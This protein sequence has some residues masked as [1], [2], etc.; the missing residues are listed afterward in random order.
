MKRLFTTLRELTFK[1]KLEHIWEYYKIQIIAFLFVVALGIS[2]Y[3]TVILNPPKQIY[4]YI[5]WRG[6]E[7]MP[8][9]MQLLGHHLSVIVDDLERQQVLV[10]NYLPS[11]IQQVDMQVASQLTAM[12]TMGEIDLLIVQYADLID[13]SR[14]GHIQNWD[15]P[16]EAVARFNPGLYEMLSTK[17]MPVTFQPLA[18]G[19]PLRT[20]FMALPLAESPIMQ[21]LGFE[22][23]RLFLCVVVNSRRLDEIARALI[24]LYAWGA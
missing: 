4:L 2:F 13:W 19:T 23:D 17:L 18:S 15:A 16:M 9:R 20:E 24:V 21:A 6:Y 22:A 7:E 5:A 8:E 10:S 11:G 1:Q 12:L 3:H 14:S